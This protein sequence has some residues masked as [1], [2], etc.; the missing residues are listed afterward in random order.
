MQTATRT[1]D[2]DT[3]LQLMRKH[4]KGSLSYSALQQ[5]MKWFV[6]PGVGFIQYEQLEHLAHNAVCL[7]DP[8]CAPEEMEGM[9]RDFIAA[10]PDPMFIHLSKEAATILAKPEFNFF[11]NEMGVET[12][13]DAQTFALTGNKKEYLRSQRNRASKDGVTV[14]EMSEGTV[15]PEQLK[16]ISE[17]WMHKKANH[18]HELAFLVR[19]AVFEYE[20]DV[21]KFIAQHNGEVVG[22]VFFD[23]MYRDGKIYGYMA[24]ILRTLGERSYSVTDYIIIEALNVFKAE[25]IEQLSLGF[26]PFLNVNDNGEFNYSKPLHDLFRYAYEH[27]NYMY[28]FKSL[29]FHK[30]RYRPDQPGAQHIT[31][32]AASTH[33]LPLFMLYGVFRKMGIKPITQTAEHAV[34]CAE[35]MLKSVPSEL[36]KLVSHWRRKDK[37]ATQTPAQT[38]PAK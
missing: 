31:V 14:A 7:G 38:P 5:G 27:A 16:R 35:E 18:D 29:A 17:E 28:S 9:F 10:F 25:G 12:I 4:G 34:H 8:V 1:A 32:Y 30:E 11:I 22:F 2:A 24:N 36:Q 21:R 26:C 6:K 20:P 15:S 33:S 13:L 19:P 3:I 37:T 23:P